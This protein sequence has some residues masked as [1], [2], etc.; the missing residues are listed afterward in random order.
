MDAKRDFL[1]GLTALIGLAG[2]A[3]MLLMFGELKLGEKDR[4]ELVLVLP[5]AKGATS[6]AVITL[7]GVEVGRVRSM[8]T[9]E[10]PRLG[11]ELV[12]GVNRGVRVP[13]NVMIGVDRDLLGSARLAMTTEHLS[14]EEASGDAGTFFEPGDRFEREARGIIEQIAAMVDERFAS[15]SG[16]ADSFK[17]LSDTYVRVG[18][19][20][21]SFVSVPEGSE[22][23]PTNLPETMAKLNAAIDDARGWLGDDELKGDAKASVSSAREA[24]AKLADAVDSWAETAETL[25]RSAD[26]VGAGFKEGLRGFVQAT[27][28]LNDALGEIRVVASKVNEGEGTLGQLLNNPDL[29]RSLDDAAQRL[30][31]A[32]R[33]AQ[34]LIEKY[35]KEG[36]PVQF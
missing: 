14:P 10:D 16:A 35:R 30:E 18:E 19:S 20:I 34:L 6:N 2:L 8:R 4:Y 11:I 29:Y 33:E 7:N 17:R 3:L 12:L 13:R 32:L 5:D 22:L 23:K 21:E 15:L 28:Q 36:V 24:L 1:V 27:D 26:R 31:T 9:F 25:R